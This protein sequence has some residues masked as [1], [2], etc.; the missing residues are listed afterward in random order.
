MVYDATVCLDI[1]CGT[2]LVH[3]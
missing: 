2:N 1:H 3:G